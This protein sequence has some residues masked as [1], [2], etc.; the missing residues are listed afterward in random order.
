MSRQL[1]SLRTMATLPVED[2]DAIVS[3][4]GEK[5]SLLRGADVWL[6]GGTG[7]FGVWLVSALLHANERLGLGLHV[8]VVAR[9]PEQL[10]ARLPEL[11][12]ATGLS[13]LAADARSF[14]PPAGMRMT[15]VIHAAT[16]ASV[17]LVESDPVEM[18][19]VAA[20]GTRNLLKV[21]RERNVERMLFTSSGAVYG[22]NPAEVTHVREE[23]MGVVDP[24]VPRNAYAE[25]KRLAETY[26]ASYFEKWQLPV[27]IARCFAFVG[28]YLPLDTH[29]AI[30]NFIRDALHGQRITVQGDGSA[31][32]SYLYATDLT[33]WLLELLL[34]GV[35]GR[36]YN[37]GS[38]CDVSIAE[39]AALVG[40][41]RGV[42]VEIRGKRD[43]SR[44]ID[45]YVPSNQ[46][47]RRELGVA[48][49]VSLE[50]SVLRTMAWH[51]GRPVA[52]DP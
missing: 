2:L 28:P 33:T 46:R 12:G 43:P 9:R 41:Q 31:R 21:A 49:L 50:Q 37:V 32:R 3:G 23:Q 20:E 26:C 24:L 18:A 6:T 35:P 8:H 1:E 7:F 38:E 25:G 16:S 19:H 15:H 10:L 22:R 11:Q 52:G 17:A 4:L 48:E 51:E 44:P 42:P 5:W 30:G 13:L 36:A 27:T 14:C 29:F 34:C 45:S 47:I 40:G 39:L